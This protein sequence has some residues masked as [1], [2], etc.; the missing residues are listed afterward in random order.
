MLHVQSQS[1]W[2]PLC[3]GPYAQANVLDDCLI[4][5]AGQ[6]PL[7]PATM[8]LVTSTTYA[9]ISPPLTELLVEQVYQ[10]IR[11]IQSTLACVDG[12]LQSLL[13][14][15]VYVDTLLQ[16]KELFVCHCVKDIV[17]NAIYNDRKKSQKYTNRSRE[18]AQQQWQHGR[19]YNSIS[20]SDE[21]REEE[22][23]RV[24]DDIEEEEL[25]QRGRDED[26][27]PLCFL[28][29]Q[30]LPRQAL[31]EL[32]V[33]GL[34]T[35]SCLSGTSTETQQP[36]VRGACM[37]NYKLYPAPALAISS[38]EPTSSSSNP[39]IDV[40]NTWPLWR[41]VSDPRACHLSAGETG[42]DSSRPGLEVDEE[43]LE[44][45]GT[46]PSISDN[47]NPTN[48]AGIVTL[49]ELFSYW[50]RCCCYCSMSVSIRDVVSQDSVD[51]PPVSETARQPSLR[52][53]CSS[54][55]A[56]LSKRLKHARM[57]Y[58]DIR[59]I[60]VYYVA[61]QV[62]RTVLMEELY[63]TSKYYLESYL[64]LPAFVCVPVVRLPNKSML[65]FVTVC[66]NIFQIKTEVWVNEPK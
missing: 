11:N 7:D 22:E 47:R 36:L 42:R 19:D 4:L 10:C 21:E 39:L 14:I 57:N 26:G 59:I 65:S 46:D 12:S 54:A 25:R 18:K 64:F 56:T 31:V 20:L 34:T 40:C 44:H 27:L 52:M 3:I 5:L 53:L 8:S 23:Q 35:H 9:N 49:S 55:L 48:V 15:I 17:N 51:L 29:V 33:I 45:A 66:I 2:A 28:F 58:S 6:L 41:C 43:R 60:R 24:G 30:G 38:C 50:D 61:D 63:I 1:E 13:G 62:Q 16:D 32:E 37:F